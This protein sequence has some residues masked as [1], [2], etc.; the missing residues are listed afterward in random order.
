M[1]KKRFEIKGGLY[2][3]VDPS[4]QFDVLH[5]KI[6]DAI[7]GGVDIIQLWNHWNDADDKIKIAQSIIELSHRFNI[8]VI[9]NENI[10]LL[11]NTDAD[12]I[13]FD[14]IPQNFDQIKS[15]LKKNSII[16]ITCSN[17][18]SKI[19]WAINN[20]LDYISFCSVFPSSSVNTCDIVSKEIII[21]TRAA[22]KMPMFLSGGIDLENINSL[23]YSK[24]NGIAVVSGIMKA[25]DAANAAQQ[26]KNALN[27]L[28]ASI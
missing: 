9:I 27:N 8:P 10:D 16:G 14:E 1:S 3:V 24:L 17:D 26:Y 5:A 7:K 20:Q 12:G 22:T 11:N 28:N 25:D 4:M 2:L 19:E 6:E 18:F 21:K 13:H 23:E 15:I